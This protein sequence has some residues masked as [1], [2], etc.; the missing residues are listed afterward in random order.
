MRIPI[1]CHKVGDDFCGDGD[2]LVN[3]REMKKK[4]EK[5]KTLASEYIFKRP[6]LTAR[7]DRVELPDGRVFDDF[8]ILE[9]SEWVNIIAT[10]PEGKYVMVRQYRHGLRDVFV[11]LCAGCVEAGED[12]MEAAKREL[13][14]ETG[15]A[16]GRWRA[17]DVLSPNPTSNTNLNHTFIA[18]GV[19]LCGDQQLDESEDI[20]VELYTADE[21]MDLLR[22]GAIK[23]SL[24]A[25]PL[26]HYFYN[27][28]EK[29]EE[30]RE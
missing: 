4:I 20:A 3:L 30:G 17:F 27:L 26:W 15:Y 23:Q 1:R 11:E 2:F 29:K 5:W 24:M 16:G 7:C 8:Y 28:K 9:Y 10:T 13:R 22:S 6:W 12:F 21:L 19:T 18:E 25:A 14:E